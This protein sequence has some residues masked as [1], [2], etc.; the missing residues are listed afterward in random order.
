MNLRCLA[1][2]LSALLTASIHAASTPAPDAKGSGEA[3]NPPTHKVARGTLK[4]KVQLDAVFEST[5][6]APIKVETKAWSDLSVLDAAAHGARVKKGETLVKFDTEKLVEQIRETEQDAPGAVIALDLAVAELANLEQTTP[7]K[8]DSTQR[9]HRIAN[10]DLA[11]FEKVGRAQR[12]KNSKFSLKSAEQRLEGAREE[13]T[14]LE[15]MYKADDLTEETEEIIL[16]RQKFAVEGAELGLE[17]SRLL[18]ERDQKTLIPREYEALKSTKR[19]QDAALTLA[20]VNL[21][22]TLAKKRLDLDKLK[23]DQKKAD[24]KLVDLKKDL[25][26]LQVTAPMEGLVYYGSCENGKWSGGAQV[27]K[28]LAPSGK[29]TANQVFMTLVDPDKLGLRA[30][31]TEAD[32]QHLKQGLKGSAAPVS[33]PDKKLSAKV[34]EVSFIPAPGGGYDVRVSF[35]KD[36]DVRL[37][38]G[39]NAKVSLGESGN[40]EV[41]LAPKEAIFT[42]GKKHF[43]YLPG[44]DGAKPE[45]RAVKIG[46][47]D[48]K[49][50]EVL[51]GL[52]DGDKILLTK[53]E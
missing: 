53:P 32:L 18:A 12:E 24:K 39:M 41:P 3:T 9:A 27:A 35:K 33:A 26:N 37:Y 46:E 38:P 5:A 10:E 34:E 22:R 6:M 1:L 43:A 17:S 48:G 36:A 15:K 29:L 14:Q 16:K 13:L 8:T 52:A 2:P 49:L 47:S 21:P 51:E 25:E 50:T 11:Y 7:L 45:K 4:A 20:E 40:G 44:K 42:E 19:D 30:S 28:S 31:A 23:R